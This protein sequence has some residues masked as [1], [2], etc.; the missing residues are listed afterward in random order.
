VTA[1]FDVQAVTP[2][3]DVVSMAPLNGTAP[4]PFFLNIDA[5]DNSGVSSVV[6][7]ANSEEFVLQYN[8]ETSHWEM[9]TTFTAGSYSLTV[10]A[11]DNVGV[12]KSLELGIL[13]LSNPDLTVSATQF[14]LGDTLIVE[15]TGLDPE[16]IATA[17]IIV[18]GPEY[19][20][21]YVI[22]NISS[23][24]NIDIYLNENYPLASYSITLEVEDFNGNNTI[25]DNGASF[26][27]F[28]N[29]NP[30]LNAV[31][32]KQVLADGEATNFTI[33]AIDSLGIENVV[34][35][36]GAETISLSVDEN[37]VATGELQFGEAGTYMIQVVATD[38][39]GAQTQST[40]IFTVNAEGPEFMN[41]YPSQTML[42]G[43]HTPFTLDIEALVM[44]G[45][46]V[47][48]VTL[49]VND[50]EYAL[51]NTFGVWY[52]SID[53]NDSTY[54]MS[55]LAVDIY[56]TQSVYDLG[57]VTP[58]ENKIPETSE[59][60]TSTDDPGP[61][62]PEPEVEIDSTIVIMGFTLLTI[63]GSSVLSWR[64]KD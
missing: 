14:E 11:I 62:I 55:L 10:I 53:L 33:E 36:R 18:S 34:I 58:Q 35:I 49:Y 38:N 40:H 3:L 48:N 37:G 56:G 51:V 39:A 7:Y 24:N 64:R 59:D 32:E 9:N 57:T 25:F 2:E 13:N 8:Q 19:S 44:D 30:S 42:A 45:S 23:S 17:K 31:F 22:A 12:E 16:V 15:V 50:T 5:T 6:L 61:T 54:T 60:P 27:I 1:T 41:V 21:E 47:A 28:T 29:S 63:I 52:T 43:L 4:Y 20:Q 46:G 26:I